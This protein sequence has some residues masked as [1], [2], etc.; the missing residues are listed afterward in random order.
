MSVAALAPRLG[1]PPWDNHPMV[2]AQAEVGHAFAAGDP[3]AM[4]VAYRQWGGL[5]HA[6]ALR[7]LGNHEDAADVTQATFISAWHGRASYDPA[8]ASLKTW[9]VA[10]ARRRVVDHLRRP[11]TSAEVPIAEPLERSG[12]GL[13]SQ[14]I[15]D[16]IVL[17]DAVTDLDEPA[18]T[19]VD[20]AFY[21]QLTHTEIADRL[22]LP[23]GT[24]KSHLRRSLLRL[25]TRLEGS[26]DDL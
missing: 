16:R 2:A 14:E 21:S 17:R 9:L 1:C 20:L 3:A 23:L 8:R 12:V 5:V 6:I 19:I 18:R 4:E 10:I 7:S 15:I 25:R 11:A 26:R 22:D 13:E 24:V